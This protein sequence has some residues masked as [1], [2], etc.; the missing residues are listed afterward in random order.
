ML[1]LN[2]ELP[3]KQFTISVDLKVPTG[4]KLCVFGRSG[5]GKSSL[6]S[7]IA[8]FE[9]NYKRAYLAVDD[10]T[11][12]DTEAHPAVFCPPWRRNIGY[13][14][15][16]PRLFPHLNVKQNILYG[17]SRHPDKEWFN[18]IV[19]AIDLK[20]L[21][22]MHPRQLSGGMAQRVA[23]ARALA[24][25][26]KVL[27][28]DEPFS[29]LDS[30]SRRGLQDLVLEIQRQFSI[31]LILVTHQLTE[32]QKMADEIA[33]IEQG[34]ILQT[35]SPSELIESPISWQAAQLMGYTSMIQGTNGEKFLMHPDRVVFGVHRELGIPIE[36]IVNELTWYEGRRRIQLTLCPP[37][38]AL[39]K[40]E[41]HLSTRE[42][43]HL[44][45][46][47]E[48]TITNPPVFQSD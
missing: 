18:R 43:V 35:G 31:T 47:I 12:I 48:V 21:L 2:L 20:E 3:R 36:G 14:E 6:L 25:K 46:R 40:P 11:L 1:R 7:A 16:S 34:I 5:T 39:G 42:P 29:A 9:Q 26:P 23:L 30:T 19:E 28:L 22:S 41:I 10:V 15:Q 8:G 17:M 33:L 24:V 38:T 4:S 13:M 27:L 32:A 44:G 45:E 37:W